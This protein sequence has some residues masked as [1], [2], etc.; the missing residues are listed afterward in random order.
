MNI[1]TDA[2][3]SPDDTRAGFVA[4]LGLPNAGKSTLLNRFLGLSL[5]AV[6]P[7]AQT[8]VR[9]TKG[10]LTRDNTQI[11]FLDMPGALDPTSLL[12]RSLALE[13]ERGLRDADAVLL[14]VDGTTDPERAGPKLIDPFSDVLDRSKVLPVVNQVDLASPQQLAAWE[15]WLS[16]RCELPVPGVSAL[17]GEGTGQVLD[18]LSALM[19]PS[20]FLYPD[21]EVAADPVRV[22]MAEIVRET[23]FEQYREEVPH[24]TFARTEEFRSGTE[25]DPT[26]IQV[27]L[28]VERSSQKAILLGKGGR[29]IRELGI[30]ARRKMEAFLDGSVYLDLWVK[31]LPGWRKKRA[32]LERF[33]FAMPPVEQRGK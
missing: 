33:G 5:A 14:L 10:I 7:R 2:E 18:R 23:L 3:E 9:T 32:A 11:I 30:E 26:Y 22:F 16:G 4:V 25:S 12:E 19:P 8:T 6:S 28:W 29:A 15:T 21:D 1:I 17:T 27:T 13:V 31:V 20:P 24:A